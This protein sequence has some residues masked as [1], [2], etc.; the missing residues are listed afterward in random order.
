MFKPDASASSLAFDATKEHF[1]NFELGTNK[2]QTTA[3][4]E[5]MEGNIINY[6]SSRD[7]AVDDVHA[8]LPL[9]LEMV[10][11]DKTVHGKGQIDGAKL[12]AIFEAHGGNAP[13]PLNMVDMTDPAGAKI[14]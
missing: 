10:D 4:E 7:I 13:N 11:A 5:V 1:V 2:N 3:A 9:T 12:T 14:G 6:S 8:A